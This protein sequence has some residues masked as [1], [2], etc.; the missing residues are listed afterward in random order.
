[1]A[2]PMRSLPSVDP[3]ER[4]ALRAILVLLVFAVTINYID[5]GNLS[6]A[7]P[8]LKDELGISP[9]QL[10]ILFSAFFWTYSTFQIVSGWLVDRFNENWFLAAGFL[11]WSGAT[12]VTGFIH[13]FAALVVIRLLLGI[14]ESAAYPSFSKILTGH[15]VEHQRGFANSA[16]DAGTKIGPAVGALVGGLYMAHYGWRSFFI[17]VGL[18]S[19][20]WLPPWIRWMPRV[21]GAHRPES[22]KPPSIT[23]IIR[24]KTAWASFAGHFAGNYF[25]YFMLTWLPYYMVKERGFSMQDMATLNSLAYLV[26]ASATT[27]TGYLSDRAIKAGAT[28]TRVRKAC[29]GYGL[30]FMTIVVGVAIIPNRAAAMILLL[31]ACLFYG[32]F[33]SSH[34]AI[35]QTLAGPVAAGKWTGVQ[36]FIANLSGVAAPAITGFVVART[37]HFFG[38]FAVAAAVALCGALAYGFVLGPVV[39]VDW[40][41]AAAVKSEVAT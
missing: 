23:N 25:F 7:A 40:S 31:V 3:T 27:V 32:I 38:A 15:Y 13:G 37:G 18:V 22:G 8:M 11:L 20:L 10:G 19:L 36:N 24:R 30:A 21:H 35:M 2:S 17:A 29:A 26:T 34:W 14:G 5:R 33:S 9:A 16:I 4:P 1:M 28:P 6:I 39:Q 41:D 12:A